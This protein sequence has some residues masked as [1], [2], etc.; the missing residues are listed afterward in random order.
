VGC[1]TCDGTNNHVGHGMQRFL[2]KGMS[3]ATLRA[4]NITLPDPWNPQPGEMVLDPATTKE[5]EIKANCAAPHSKPTVCDPRL[6][7]ANAQ[8]ACGGP[9]D[10]YYWSPWRSPG[11][12]PVLD[13]CGSAGG[14]FP[15]QGTGGAG[16][17]FQNSSVA[18]AGD[19]GSKLPRMPSQ[20][21]WTAGSTG[22]VG[23]T[24]MAHHG[25]GYAY[26]LAPADG[27]LTEEEFRKIPLD[28]AGNS[29]LRWDGDKS[30][31]L[32][33]DA[34]ARGWETS[35]GT[36]P[37]GSSWRK[38]PIPTVLWEREGPSFEPVCEE[39]AAC[40]AAASAQHG[41]QGV[42]K[43]SGH[44]NGG[45]LLPNLE[46]VDELKIPAGLAPGSYVL[47]FRWD[48]EETD[49]VWLSCS[50]VTVAAPAATD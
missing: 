38:N 30:G 35:E 49:Q 3:A 19:V 4:K 5:L 36:V 31:Q 15:G 14:R 50:D 23:W 22:E 24:V 11:A 25:G 27:P 47:Q 8:A 37:A 43:C 7:T 41:P 17:Q 21:T 10:V 44:S 29:A 33:F 28:F 40:K 26:R 12:A 2:Y 32:E 18:R 1:D 42:C 34:A 48:C 13:A 20:A 45:P 16:A 39:S 46:I 6:R 9:E